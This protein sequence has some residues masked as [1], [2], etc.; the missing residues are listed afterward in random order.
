MPGGGLPDPARQS[1]GDHR[2]QRGQA[3]LP[4][5]EVVGAAALQRVPLNVDR[6]GDQSP[7]RQIAR[8]Q[9]SVGQLLCQSPEKRCVQGP[10]GG[11]HLHGRR[12]HTGGRLAPWNADGRQRPESR[13]VVC[14][15]AG[16]GQ[17]R[18]RASEKA[19][20]RH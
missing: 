3:D 10:E 20:G 7:G 4:D 18:S 14:G 17:C 15:Q 16:T 13:R 9:A 1:G 6:G 2:R 19:A 11:R 8:S 12:H 5:V